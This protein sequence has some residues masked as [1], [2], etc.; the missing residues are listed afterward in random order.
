MIHDK[1]H[2]Y[3]CEIPFDLIDAGLV[4]HHPNY[5]ILCERARMQCMR[6]AGCS[7]YEAWND[8]ITFAIRENHSEYFKP[9]RMGQA[10]SILTHVS[11]VSQSTLEVTQRIIFGH[12]KD[13][14]PFKNGIIEVDQKELIYRVKM[15][16]VCIYRDTFKP[17]RHPEK[18]IKALQLPIKG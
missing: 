13:E 5:L 17:R 12:P 16:L 14:P 3:F 18:I 2:L 1:T 11:D 6:D 10:I 8:N 15:K 7:F 9:I 4:V